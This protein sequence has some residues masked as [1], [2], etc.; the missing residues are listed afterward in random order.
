M[1]VY[2]YLIYF[3][4]SKRS[5]PYYV[6][7]AKNL[8]RRMLQHFDSKFQV[9]N[10]LRKY[11]DWVIKKLH[12]CKTYEEAFKIEIEEI[13]NFNCVAPNGYNLTRGGD[14]FFS[15][16]TEASKLKIS[17]AHKGKNLGNPGN[18]NHLGIK[19]SE[20]C[21]KKISVAM[22]GVRVGPKNSFYGKRHTKESKEKNRQAHL[23]KKQSKKTILK[24]SITQLRN[25]INRLDNKDVDE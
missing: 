20:A 23:G 7:V 24:R 25:K 14:G 13:R 12:T 21:K 4:T 16:H 22:Q 9:G 17:K 19:R 5:N 15:N 2:V 18:R 1:K 3:P 8:E 11:D 10:A 6:G